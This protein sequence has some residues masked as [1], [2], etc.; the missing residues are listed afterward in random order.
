MIS[1][2]H[3]QS[4]RPCAGASDQ[5]IG[6][7]EAVELTRRAVEVGEA[8]H[9]AEGRFVPGTVVAVMLGGRRLHQV[10]RREANDLLTY[11]ARIER[12]RRTFAEVAA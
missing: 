8:S 9:D 5:R 1:M 2:P 10:T 12:E 7:G 3:G 6:F 4:T 11:F